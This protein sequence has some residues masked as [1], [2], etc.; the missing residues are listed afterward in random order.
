MFR[1]IR[2]EVSVTAAVG[3][4]VAVQVRPPSL[5]LNPLKVPLATLRSALSRPMTASLKVMVT[6][7]VSPGRRSVSAMTMVAVGRWLSIA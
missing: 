6:R 4:K 3:V 7:V 2:L 5:L 1:L